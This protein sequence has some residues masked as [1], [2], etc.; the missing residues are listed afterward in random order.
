M[1]EIKI[2][3][4]ARSFATLDPTEPV[5]FAD[6]SALT[7]IEY[8]TP[9]NQYFSSGG[10]DLDILAD[11]L[12]D[13]P[14]VQAVVMYSLRSPGGSA[15]ARA[16]NLLASM[17]GQTLQ[18]AIWFEAQE[19]FMRPVYANEVWEMLFRALSYAEGT[20][21][22]SC[23]AWVVSRLESPNSAKRLAASDAAESLSD[24]YALPGASQ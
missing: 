7:T 15:Q 6:D 1:P 4:W 5:K 24:M 17:I 8:S 3:D 23:Y 13:P 14:P 22:E 9:L 12:S 20:F 2:I 19:R 18:F 10:A 11:I 16:V 21:G